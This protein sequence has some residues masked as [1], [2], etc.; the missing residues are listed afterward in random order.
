MSE[1][2]HEHGA[3]DEPQ[4]DGVDD[5]A[6][7]GDEPEPHVE[8]DGEPEG[9]D[10]LEARLG[11]ELGDDGDDERAPDGDDGP[12]APQPDAAEIEK[13]YERLDKETARHVKRVAELVGDEA[14]NFLVP[15]ELC[16]PSIPGFHWPKQ[17][18]DEVKHAVRLAIG[19]RE[20]EN[21][22]A[23]QYS[24]RCDACDGLGEVLTGSRVH[25]KGTLPCLACGGNGW[26]PIGDERRGV[27][28]QLVPRTAPAAE[29]VA[30]LGTVATAGAPGGPD[31]ATAAQLKALGYIVLDP[32]AQG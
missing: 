17:P 28:A 13:T 25:G 22:Q 4:P 1:H 30:D 19:D 18:S 31:P 15:C 7:H 6:I 5:D 23:D 24:R 21:W 8:P 20:P 27:V 14:F 29:Q 10:E 2:E 9:D 3:G 16:E 32:P 11:A 26:S 12:A